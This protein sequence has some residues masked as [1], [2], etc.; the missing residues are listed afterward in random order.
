MLIG[1]GVSG[2]QDPPK[3]PFP[4]LIG[5]T[6]TTVLHY[7][8]DGDKCV[9]VCVVNACSMPRFDIPFLSQAAR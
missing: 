2:R 4:I 6:L 3:V 8:A 7:R 5:T 9:C 1:Q